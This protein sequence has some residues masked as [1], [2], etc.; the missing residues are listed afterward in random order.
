MINQRAEHDEMSK[1]SLTRENEE[2][3][4]GT[5]DA[6]WAAAFVNEDLVCILEL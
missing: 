5:E 4:S 2:V 1:E 6:M 3:E